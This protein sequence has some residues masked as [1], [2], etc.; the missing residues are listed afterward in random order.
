MPIHINQIVEK[1]EKVK[2]GIS[3]IIT[4]LQTDVIFGDIS[5]P[6]GVK[7]RRRRKPGPKPGTKREKTT[8]TFTPAA[9]V[10]PPVQKKIVSKPTPKP[11]PKKPA[12]KPAPKKKETIKPTFKDQ[13]QPN[14][15][16]TE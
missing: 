5:R 14:L 6:K 16:S 15:P 4:T 12:T 10:S 8:T 13:V 2:S 7:V 9:K 3:D 1:L 11:T